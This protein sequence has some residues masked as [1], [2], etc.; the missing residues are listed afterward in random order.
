M[1][2]KEL[3]KWEKQTVSRV[4]GGSGGGACLFLK[5]TAGPARMVLAAGCTAT[6]CDVIETASQVDS[7]VNSAGPKR[8]PFLL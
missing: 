7:K 3:L 4:F 5:E 8:W 6:N 1:K 2:T